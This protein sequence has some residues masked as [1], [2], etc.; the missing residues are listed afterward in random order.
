MIARL[1][2]LLGLESPPS[3]FQRSPGPR[4]VDSKLEVTTSTRTLPSPTRSRTKL[5][6]YLLS[7]Y[8]T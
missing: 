3:P 5:R 7:N 2:L 8:S 1:V 6:L 4:K